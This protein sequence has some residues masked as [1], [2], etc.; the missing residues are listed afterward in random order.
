LTKRVGTPTPGCFTAKSAEVIEKK[1][2][3]F[4]RVPKSA[5]ECEKKRDS[6]EGGIG[7][8]K[9]SILKIKKGEDSQIESWG[10]DG[11]EN[12]RHIVP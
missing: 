12:S 4:W 6:S 2:V 9:A 11:V 7:A 3:E 5:Q 8:K 1:G 10:G